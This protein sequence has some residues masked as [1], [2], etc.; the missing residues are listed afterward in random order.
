MKIIIVD[1]EYF[2][3]MGI[4]AIMN[5]KDKKYTVVGEEENGKAA[6]KTILELQPDLVFLD[7]TMPGMDGMEVL[8]QIRKEGYQGYVVMLTCHEDFELARQ[9][10]RF[11]ADDYVLKN[12]LIGDSLLEYLD[13]ISEKRENVSGENERRE[14]QIQEEQHFYKE[15]FLKNALLIGGLSRDEFI[16]GCSRYKV[17]IHTDNIYM[18]MIHMKHWN[19]IVQRYKDSDLQT[20]FSTVDNMMTEIFK[21]YP[22]WDGF[23]MQPFCYH[24]L[25][26]HSREKSV[27]AL[28]EKI[29]GIVGSIGH[30][31]E[32]ILDIEFAIAVYRNIYPVNELCE[33]Y[34]E[35]RLLMDQ[36]FFW[37][38]AKLFW[39]GIQHVYQSADLGELERQMEHRKPEDSMQELIEEYL[40]RQKD[41]LIN[42]EEFFE[43]IRKIVIPATKEHRLEVNFDF[44]GYETVTE[45]LSRIGRLDE[46]IWAEKDNDSH[47]HLIKQALQIVK[48]N[49]TKRLTLEETAEQL[50]ISEGHFSRMFSAEMNETFSNYII[51]KRVEYAKK[52][53][54]TTNYKFYEIGELCGFSSSV[55][56]NNTFKKMY[57][58]TPNQYRKEH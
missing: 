8:A 55:H 22:E 1:D 17:R 9:A 44:S 32:Q 7:I 56:F 37:P 18:I 24:I 21:E 52:L 54:V 33:G 15:N 31:L 50:G 20:F 36:S 23:Y 45:L 42:R 28:E 29:R 49:F 51:R 10:M 48:Q 5:Q 58:M 46:S 13:I 14:E 4:K 57:G 26:T 35:A 39:N 40:F 16:R 6:V 27:M 43:V 11:G 38:K 41:Y 30:H 47:S 53:I 19:A 2:V 3:R 25:F 12:E 34:R